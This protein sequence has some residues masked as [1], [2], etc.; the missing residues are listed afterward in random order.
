MYLKRKT[1]WLS[2]CASLL[3]IHGTVT[4]VHLG[5]YLAIHGDAL[6]SN[7]LFESWTNPVAFLN[8]SSPVLI[9]AISLS[10]LSKLRNFLWL[11]RHGSWY[12]LVSSGTVC[13]L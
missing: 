1:T 10:M 4:S 7:V 11:G 2:A 13:V 5:I 9:D 8:D 3:A 12:D 6:P